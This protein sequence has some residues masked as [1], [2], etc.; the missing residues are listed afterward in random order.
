MAALSSFDPPRT[1]HSTGI[2]IMYPDIIPPF[3]MACDFRR[4]SIPLLRTFLRLLTPSIRC[5]NPLQ[6][7]ILGIFGRLLLLIVLF[8]LKATP[9][10]SDCAI[11][12]PELCGI[13]YIW[14][15]GE[16]A[17]VQHP[18]KQNSWLCILYSLRQMLASHRRWVQYTVPALRVF[19][20]R[21]GHRTP[22][23]KHYSP[24]Q[25]ASGILL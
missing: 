3:P 15:R 14:N 24:A 19:P 23:A 2:P 21:T 20:A 7:R 16:L 18:P 11:C 12:A 22:Q 1:S 6:A 17:L 8:C 9:H 4:C 10:N 5:P 25:L 13:A